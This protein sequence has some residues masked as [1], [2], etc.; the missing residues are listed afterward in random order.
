[1]IWYQMVCAPLFNG[2]ENQYLL[3]QN[4]MKSILIEDLVLCHF[5]SEI[6]LLQFDVLFDFVLHY[7]KI[8]SVI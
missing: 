3:L 2:I 4:G 6:I 5:N 1:M 7:L 8:G